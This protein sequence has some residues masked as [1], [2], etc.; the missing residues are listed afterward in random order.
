MA[1]HL[2]VLADGRIIAVETRAADSTM[3]S[4]LSPAE[5]QDLLR[6]AI[7]EQR[8]FGIDGAAVKRKMDAEDAR[9]GVSLGVDDAAT[10]R[11]RIATAAGS[12]EASIYALGTYALYHSNIPELGQLRAIERRLSR[13]LEEAR[14]GGKQW[15][16]GGVELANGFLRQRH[17]ELPLLTAADFQNVMLYEASKRKTLYFLQNRP[18][19]IST[20]VSVDYR[21]GQDARVTVE[22]TPTPPPR[23]LQ[24]VCLMEVS[25]RLVL[26]NGPLNQ[27]ILARLE[28]Q[29]PGESFVAFVA[30][31]GSF[32][33]V[34]VPPGKYK[35]S[36]RTTVT[37]ELVTGRT[38]STVT[39]T[40]T[41]PVI[42]VTD[43]NVVDLL[44]PFNA[45]RDAR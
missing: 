25:G 18:G 24:K 36:L 30:A 37:T 8:F 1:P 14:A 26:L 39:W 28:P 21:D 6:F 9:C 19:G 17:P 40:E 29:L 32:R 5:L 12:H 13:I 15:V 27:T 20:D 16:S 35:L 10:T 23:T 45:V 34:G 11:I 31:N 7:N 38:M 22:V 4:R 41:D 44:V 3:E 42:T 43:R 2:T 33:F